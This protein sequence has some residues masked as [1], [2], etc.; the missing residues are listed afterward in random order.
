[1]GFISVRANALAFWELGRT[2]RRHAQ[3]TWE[4]TKRELTDKYAG[5]AF[6]AVWALLHP[7]LVM[8]VYIFVFVVVFAVRVDGMGVPRDYSTYLLA[9]LIPWL[10]FTEA[11]NKGVLSLTGN[12]NLVKQVVFPLEVL[13]A[14]SSLASLINQLI[15]MTLLTGYVLVTQGG[16]PW[17]F[18]LLP[19]LMGLQLLGMIGICC[20][21]GSVGPYFRDLKEFVQVFTL[22]GV[23][24]VPVVYLPSMVPEI[25]RPVLYLNPFSYMT[26]CYQDALYFGEFRHPWAWAVF[27][28]FSLALFCLGYRVFKKL[29]PM[30]GNVL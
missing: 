23:Y 13:P 29:K 6:G 18:A 3:L 20:F 8:A 15:F 7:T 25:F 30:L 16:L 28:L 11:M 4:M 2:L 14:K 12:A 5:Q 24:L 21:L 26:W 10:T 1:M 22:V 17:T 19:V 27:P 9:G